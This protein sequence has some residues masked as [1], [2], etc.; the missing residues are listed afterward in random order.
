MGSGCVVGSTSHRPARPRAR[1]TSAFACNSFCNTQ[2]G[3]ASPLALSHAIAVCGAPLFVAREGRKKEERNSVLSNPRLH[4]HATSIRLDTGA[5]P[6]PGT[7]R[8]V[9]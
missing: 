3:N 6:A 1:P 4:L 8:T 2:H 9:P 7:N 5:R